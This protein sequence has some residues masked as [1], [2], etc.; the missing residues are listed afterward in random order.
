[1]KI[2]QWYRD[3]SVESA[4]RLNAS[5]VPIRLLVTKPGSVNAT[6]INA[7]INR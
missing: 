1:M 5:A 2:F 4:A 7:D 3:S 6:E